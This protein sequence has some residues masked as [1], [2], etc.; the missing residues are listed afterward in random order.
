LAGLSNYNS[1]GANITIA[2]GA[3]FTFN[4]TPIS[5][6][7][8]ITQNVDNATFNITKTGTYFLQF[9]AQTTT[10]SLLGNAQFYLN[11]TAIGGASKLLVGGAP[12]ILF[13][14]LQL[15]A[16]DLPAA[17]QVRGGGALLTLNSGATNTIFISQLSN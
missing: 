14:L 4:Q 9:A 13:T 11:G 8:G 2:A 17:I 12:L 10:L 3:A 1:S 7:T 6:G 5:F 16:G 15:N